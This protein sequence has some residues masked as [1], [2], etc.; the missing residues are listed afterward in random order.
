MFNINAQIKESNQKNKFLNIT[1]KHITK[2]S[3]NSKLKEK[4]YI[5]EK[6]HLA[7]KTIFVLHH[8]LKINKWGGGLISLGEGG[9]EKN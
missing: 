7:T 2:K 5:N 8:S 4:Y 6:A 9:S 3:H 1:R